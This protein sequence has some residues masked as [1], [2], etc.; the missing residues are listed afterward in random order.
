MSAPL[1]ATGAGL[2]R[3]AAGLGLWLGA[4]T[5][6]TAAYESEMAAFAAQDAA[7][8][9]PA[10]VIVFTGSSSF[11]K[12]TNLASSFPG[13]PV[14]NR[15]F[16]GS[17]MSDVLEHFD[18]LVKNYRPPLVVL[19]EG[20][21]DIAEGLTPARVFL[22]YA[23]FVSRVVTELP[24]T[25][26]AIVSVKPSPSRASSLL[27]MQD[28]NNRL[29]A[30]C[31]TS[32]HL[33]FVDIATPMLNS[34]GQ[35]RPE[36]F[37]SDMLHMNP[38]GYALWTG[39]LT[40]VL[41]AAPF[42]TTPA[43][44]F[45]FGS[46][47]SP[48]SQ[49]LPPADPANFWNN[50]NVDTGTAA[51]ARL[52][53]LITADGR[54]SASSLV[55]VQPFNS[56][57]ES[58]PGQP[59]LFPLSAEHDSLFGNV[60]TFNGKEDIAP[61]FKLTGLDPGL[62]YRFTFLAARLGVSDNRTTFYTV[63]GANEATASLDAAANLTGLTA[64]VTGIA[65]DAAGEIRIALT[66][67]PGNNSSS[68]FTYLN[69]LRVDSAALEVPDTTPPAIVSATAEDSQTI[70][71]LFTEKLA[72]AS[73][74]AAGAWN[75]RGNAGGT[76]SFSASLGA[77]GKTVRLQLTAPASGTA[78]VQASGITDRAG[79]IFPASAL[80]EVVFPD[81]STQAFLLD[82]GSSATVT[83][84]ADDAQHT[85]NNVPAET[86]SSATAV[87]ANL[88]T[89]TGHPSGIS[90]AMIRRFNGAN[91]N[92]TTSSGILPASA[93]RDSLFGNT[94]NFSSLANIFPAFKLTGLSPDLPYDLTFHASRTGVADNRE[95]IYTVTGGA[96]SST[97]LDA[98]NNIDGTAVL[99]G[100]R[101][102]LTGEI[103]IALS[104]GVH[105]TNANHFTYLGSLRIEAAPKVSEVR[106]LPPSATDGILTLDW[107]GEGSLEWAAS[108]S[109]PWI[110]YN[111]A[112]TRPY[113]EDLPSAGS[114]FFRLRAVRP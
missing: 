98:A 105:N 16:G 96:V 100:V 90:L 56:A 38:D 77:D 23:A 68:H 63:T 9:P 89:I 81:L 33:H 107:S 53:P 37:V 31:A 62:R 106:M 15:G 83:S 72:P 30:L 34:S 75:V 39:I 50:V 47:S 94:E 95:T 26:I 110:P 80:T 13:F 45:D 6:G 74:T 66:P 1:S 32:G 60:E 103:T 59:V 93:T 67:G 57:N 73:V 22:D 101:P 69:A 40:P 19:Y 65:P 51:G 85:W 12:W 114:K 92:G 55:M 18:Q 14:L 41:K 64:V 97:S 2:L 52:E 4:V 82:F 58:G 61:V 11:T 79:N 104:P 108:P 112:P 43:F 3:A 113:Q 36:L 54:T 27:A 78:T 70:A 17:K 49:G 87:L 24:G 91:T 76:L 102:S 99:P 111:P 35:P 21:N 46:A 25:E 48:T 7:R 84:P 86:G 71:I 109:G 28:L 5:P 29:R 44:L 10:N 88:K 42:S 20:D 8:P